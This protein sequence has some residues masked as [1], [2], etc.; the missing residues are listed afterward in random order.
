M[1]RN[2]NA[3]QGESA[4]M[5]GP[6][7]NVIQGYTTGRSWAENSV[8]E[9]LVASLND[10][11]MV[12]VNLA[13][14]QQSINMMAGRL[15]QLYGFA[16]NLRRGNVRKALSFLSLEP[17]GVKAKGVKRRSQTVGNVWLEYHFGWEPLI[18]DVHAACTLLS[19][20]LEPSF[21]KVS[22][23]PQTLRAFIADYGGCSNSSLGKAW[24]ELNGKIRSK[25]G[26]KIAISNPNLYLANRLGLVNP[27]AVAWELVPFSFVVDWF[28]NVSDVINEASD[29]LGV[30]ITDPYYGTTC[31][32]SGTY[33]NRSRWFCDKN[34]SWF[35]IGYTKEGLYAY[36]EKGIPAVKLGVR[37]LKR[38]SL[39]RA[40]TAIALLLQ[41]LK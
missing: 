26:A 22:G 41:Q 19:D 30:N 40:A 27:A 20:P 8:R 28:V 38:L 21:V 25:G 10:E 14:R 15:M 11:A 16:K 24:I 9:K 2:S 7:P 33:Y 6:D 36:R 39:T 4:Y 5:P 29:F 17:S 18:K 34:Q 3:L 1:P 13:E 32:A 31:K 23:K 12:A 35:T 37:P